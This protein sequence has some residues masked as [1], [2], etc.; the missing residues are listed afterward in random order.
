MNI[1][2]LARAAY[3]TD[4]SELSPASVEVQRKK[5][6]EESFSVAIRQVLY[7]NPSVDLTLRGINPYLEFHDGKLF[8][9]VGDEH[10]H[11]DDVPYQLVAL[12]EPQTMDE[13]PSLDSNENVNIERVLLEVGFRGQIYQKLIVLYVDRYDERY[14]VTSVVTELCSSVSKDQE[15]QSSDDD[16]EA[17]AQ[18][19]KLS[20]KNIGFR[21]WTSGM[22]RW[23]LMECQGVKGTCKKA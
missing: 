2:L 10:R 7:R 16:F 19:L 4:K 15:F 8:F 9:V 3:V 18:P 20:N 22:V 1:F 21:A 11:P 14:L 5:V 12:P 23:Q 17:H 6:I 13:Q